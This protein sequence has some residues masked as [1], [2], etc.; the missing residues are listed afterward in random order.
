MC[1]SW[2]TY[3]YIR[4]FMKRK[5]EGEKKEGRLVVGEHWND[6]GVN[7]GFHHINSFEEIGLGYSLSSLS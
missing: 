6:F 3:V 4:I 1:P 7:F 2:H 5:K